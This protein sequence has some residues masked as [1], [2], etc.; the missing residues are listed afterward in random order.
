MQLEAHSYLERIGTTM[1]TAA[2]SIVARVQKGG[3]VQTSD[4]EAWKSVFNH[5]Y[6]V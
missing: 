5:S 4:H 1:L 2:N 3:D 6:D